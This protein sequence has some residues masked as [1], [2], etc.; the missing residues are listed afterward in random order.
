[1]KEQRQHLACTKTTFALYKDNIYLIQ[2]RYRLSILHC[3]LYL[4]MQ[5]FLKMKYDLKGLSILTQ[6]IVIEKKIPPYFS[7]S[8]SK[9]FLLLSFLK[10]IF[11]KFHFLIL[12]WVFLTL[13]W[14]LVLD[15][16]ILKWSFSFIF[17]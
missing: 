17:R 8:I 1:M 10:R 16:L 7:T 14:N 4:N 3:T 15:F 9:T 13:I 12:K 5:I 2:R 6:K 11:L